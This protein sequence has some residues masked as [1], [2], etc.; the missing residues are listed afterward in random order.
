VDLRSLTQGR[1]TFL[2]SFSHYEELQ[3]D[4]QAK[5]IADSQSHH[6]ELAKK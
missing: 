1:A 4:L 6:E 3:R 2:R 5:V